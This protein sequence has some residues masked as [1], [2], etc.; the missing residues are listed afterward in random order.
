MKIIPLNNAVE[1]QD[2]D[3]MDD[4]QCADL[5]RVVAEESVVLVRQVIPEL[6]LHEIQTLWG[7]PS[8]SIVERYMMNKRLTGRHWRS[9]LLNLS[10]AM[11]SK[12]IKDHRTGLARVSYEKNEKGKPVGFFTNG[13]LDW[14]SDHQ[15]TFDSQTVVGLMSLWGSENSQTSF[16]CTAKAYSKLSEDDRSMVNELISVWEWDGG[17]MSEDLIAGQKEFLRYNMAP[18]TD[19]ECPLLSETATGVKGIRF[20]SHS[21]SHFKGM[22]KPESEKYRSYLWGILNTPENIYL[23]DWKDGEM[24]FMD[25]NITLHARPT[26][27]KDG[28]KRTMARM[29]SYMDR[30][31][32]DKGPVDYVMCEGEK[33][34]HD[35]F[36]AMVDAQR[37]Q[38]FYV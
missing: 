11:N 6:R 33:Y 12:N 28:D 7:Q 27:V 1:V 29:I 24:I 3:L 37:R 2:I 9:L 32:P 30:L 15:S 21:F 35:T 13:E 5:G 23:H 38:E 17:K 22:S 20:P 34:D 26:N 18:H 16:L 31:Y 25:Q 10:R 14:H 19:M 4:D 8:L 36:A